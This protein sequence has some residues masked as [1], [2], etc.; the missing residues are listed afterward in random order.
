MTP[1]PLKDFVNRITPE[2]GRTTQIGPPSMSLISF[3]R[4]ATQHVKETSGCSRSHF[5]AK[6]M[7]EAGVICADIRKIYE[8]LTR[9]YL[10]VYFELESY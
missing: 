6:Q 1:F 2:P 4:R 8:N 5:T 3:A 10:T 9:Y 7:W